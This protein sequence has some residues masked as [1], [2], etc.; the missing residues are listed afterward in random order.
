MNGVYSLL[1]ISKWIL[2]KKF[3]ILMIYPTIC[4]KYNKKVLIKMLQVQMGMF[5]GQVRMLQF[6]LEGGIT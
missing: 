2:A 4:K 5:Q 3:R 6:Y 1:D